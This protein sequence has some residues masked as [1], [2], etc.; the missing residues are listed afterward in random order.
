MRNLSSF[1]Q[2]FIQTL[3]AKFTSSADLKLKQ[4]DEDVFL[5]GNVCVAQLTTTG[6][7]C[8]QFQ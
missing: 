8:R 1:D 4:S 2:C 7:T 5:D 3:A 6:A